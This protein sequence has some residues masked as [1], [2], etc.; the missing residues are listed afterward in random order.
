[1]LLRKGQRCPVCHSFWCQCHGT[2]VRKEKGASKRVQIGPGVYKIPDQHH[3]RGYRVHRTKSAMRDLLVK[4][5]E[6]QEGRCFYCHKEFQ[7]F[8][9]VTPDHRE[10]R[11]MGGARRDDDSSNIVACCAACNSE[12]GSKRL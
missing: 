1:M 5:V 3:P 6:E 2:L 4:K 12:K 11:G 7:T 10:P 8:A 9:E